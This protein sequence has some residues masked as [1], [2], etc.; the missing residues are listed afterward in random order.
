MATPEGKIENYL[1]KR[2]R[3]TGGKTRKLKWIG[4][5]GAPD[6]ICWWP[7]VQHLPPLVVFVEVKAPGK[8]PTKQQKQEHKKL[9]DDGHRV[10]VVDS[11][12]AADDLVLYWNI[13]WRNRP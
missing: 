5:N 3:E 1:I 10:V 4:H 6:R 12:E 9:Q 2:V 7:D 13:W 8:K 11:K